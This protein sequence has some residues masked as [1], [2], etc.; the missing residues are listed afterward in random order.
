MMMMRDNKPRNVL[1]GSSGQLFIAGL[2]MSHH[3]QNQTTILTASAGTLCWKPKEAL[4]PKSC[5][6]KASDIQV[7]GT[8]LY[9]I[10]TDGHHP[11]EV[12]LPYKS[13]LHG[14]TTPVQLGSIENQFIC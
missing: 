11:F 1:I 9:Y 3:L 13:E 7:V 2:G 6:K 4:T 12:M 14:V 8:L 10:L 5:Y